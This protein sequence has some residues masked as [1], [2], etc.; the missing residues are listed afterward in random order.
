MAHLDGTVEGETPRSMEV[1]AAATEAE[2]Q[3]KVDELIGSL[4]AESLQVYLRSKA[5]AEGA[6]L[7]GEH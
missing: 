1:A 3:G 5:A 7:H 2:L 4:A 6:L